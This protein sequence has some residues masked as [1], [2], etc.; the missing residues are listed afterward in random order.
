MTSLGLTWSLNPSNSSRGRRG[1]RVP[2]G[3]K[4]KPGLR[5]RRAN[6]ELLDQK[7]LR[8][9]RE[10]REPQDGRLTLRRELCSS[11]W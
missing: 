3:H 7:D 4:E 9:N 10:I 8:V 6:K 11:R 2:Q 5:D 1:H